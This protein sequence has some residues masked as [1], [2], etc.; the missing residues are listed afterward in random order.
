MGA[1]TELLSSTDV[2]TTYHAFSDVFA[3]DKAPD[4][5]PETPP[6]VGPRVAPL[7]G[8]LKWGGLVAGV[9][10]LIVCAIMMIMGRRS[11]NQTA[12]EGAVGI[13]WVLAGLTI[14]AF[15]ATL[16]NGVFFER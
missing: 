14:I 5:D 8:W 11:R 12:I 4:A 3:L 13:P 10:G 1:I 15:S 9:I 2:V 7:I 16:V 6:G